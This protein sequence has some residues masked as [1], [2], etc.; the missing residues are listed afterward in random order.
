MGKLHSCGI[1]LEIQT[2]PLDPEPDPW[3]RDT[4]I[5]TSNLFFFIVNMK[6]R[7]EGF[8]I[9]E[10]YYLTKDVDRCKREI[11][12]IPCDSFRESWNHTH[13]GMAYSIALCVG[14]ER[15]KFRTP[16]LFQGEI[17]NPARSEEE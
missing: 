17:Y 9:D 5:P 3:R 2:D 4:T 11:D 13:V 15:K 6:V 8:D 7:I 12:L 10:F 1:P 16:P 14:L